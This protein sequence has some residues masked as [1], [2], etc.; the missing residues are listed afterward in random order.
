MSVKDRLERGVDD[1]QARKAKSGVNASD[2]ERKNAELVRKNEEL[3][4]KIRESTNSL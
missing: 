3:N 2:L 1:L 4:K